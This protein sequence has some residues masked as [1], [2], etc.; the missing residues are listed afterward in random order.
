[1][2][3]VDIQTASEGINA[4]DDD[5]FKRWVEAALSAASANLESELSIR[6][7]D[8]G[9]SQELNQRYR[10]IDKP[11]NVLS[12]ACEI[13]EEVDI[14]LLGDL[15]I[16]HTVVEQEAKEQNKSIESHW[17]HMVIHGTLHL[18]GYDHIDDHEAED[19]EKLETDIMNALGYENPYAEN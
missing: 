7:V 19:M 2:A 9:E 14:N 11:T 18:L 16:C 17:A 15:V 4:P 13:P 6:I 3:Q 5:S 10:G 12:F 8:N 1:M